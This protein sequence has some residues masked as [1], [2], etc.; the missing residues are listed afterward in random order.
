M[1]SS[2]LSKI[3]SL[4]RDNKKV[5]HRIENTVNGHPDKII[6]GPSKRVNL[7]ET[8]LVC[9]ETDI[10]G[11]PHICLLNKGIYGFEDK[12]FFKW[13]LIL[14]INYDRLAN[15]GMPKNEDVGKMQDFF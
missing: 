6:K 7:P 12:A 4:L 5:E 13:F 9:A 11:K 10:D 1:N 14:E 2:I 15:A 3:G 8:S